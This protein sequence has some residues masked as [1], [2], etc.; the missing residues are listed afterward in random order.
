MK[1]RVDNIFR[2]P[3]TYK[4]S[5]PTSIFRRHN[6]NNNQQQQPSN[7]SESESYVVSCPATPKPTT[8]DQQQQQ[9][10]W[11]PHQLSN[12]IEVGA[13]NDK[14]SI[15]ASQSS[16]TPNKLDRCNPLPTQETTNSFNVQS[17][18][19]TTDSFN[20]DK[21]SPDR[22]PLS[23]SKRSLRS[24]SN[25]SK[26]P[27]QG[28]PKSNSRGIKKIKPPSYYKLQ[29]SK[30]QDKASLTSGDDSSVQIDDEHNL[31]IRLAT[32]ND[33]CDSTVGES[34]RSMR[35]ER[36]RVKISR[37]SPIC[38]DTSN[39]EDKEE[40][41][42]EYDALNNV[43]ITPDFGINSST[44]A[45][46]GEGRGEKMKHKWTVNSQG[47][48]II[49]P[50]S[51]THIASEQLITKKARHHSPV[52]E[53]NLVPK[54]APFT[55]EQPATTMTSSINQP[56]LMTVSN[57]SSSNSSFISSGEEETLEGTTFLTPLPTS[58][59]GGS[60]NLESPP[61]M[62]R[63]SRA[64]GTAYHSLFRGDESDGSRSSGNNAA[65]N[66]SSSLPTSG[67]RRQRSISPNNS[68]GSK[69]SDDGG[70]CTSILTQ[71]LDVFSLNGNMCC[72]QEVGSNE[73][74]EGNGDYLRQ[75]SQQAQQRG[76]LICA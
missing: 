39:E 4:S 63:H 14:S 76:V 49:V 65:A 54:A 46:A 60:S 31:Q 45:T 26:S 50:P 69:T 51:P 48:I 21:S 2:K 38:E 74:V 29:F 72:H 62:T 56:I 18:F 15:L 41:G 33:C 3:L 64:F 66:K 19:G 10:Q 36:Q 5:S 13:V 28:T 30:S 55:D 34:S 23:S 57:D 59:S 22:S 7:S 12:S 40:E 25:S 20:I 8:D 52:K 42:I 70:G 6:N 1:T 11:P 67:K 47:Q 58:G 61:R 17:I 75:H 35:E 37:A 73:G 32:T 44:T 43:V 68:K 9:Q 16:S 24:L 27:K 71:I 53:M